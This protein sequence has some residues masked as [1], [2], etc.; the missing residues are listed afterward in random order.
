M[1]FGLNGDYDAIPDLES[2]AGYL[3]DAVDALIRAAKP[4]RPRSAGAPTR[5]RGPRAS[6]SGRLRVIEAE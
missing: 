4:A 3:R 5:E 2:I 6:R 1:S